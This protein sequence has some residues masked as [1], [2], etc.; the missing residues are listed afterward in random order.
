[1]VYKHKYTA[2]GN[3]AVETRIASDQS[4]IANAI[5]KDIPEHLFVS[6]VMIGGYARGEGGFSYVHGR[7]QAY[8]DYDYFLITEDLSAADLATIK[9]KLVVL[10]KDLE[11]EVGVEVD[12]F[13][14]QRS[15]LKT[16]PFTLMYAEMQSGHLVIAGDT[17]ILDEMPRMPL[18]EVAMSEFQRLMINRGSLLLLNK[19]SFKRDP[20]GFELDQ[21]NK[22]INKAALAVGDSILKRHGAYDLSYEVKLAR[23]FALNGPPESLI[24]YYTRAV[25]QKF[26]PKTEGLDR[27]ELISMQADVIELWCKEFEQISERANLELSQRGLV[28]K[29]KQRLRN[30]AV[31]LRDFGASSILRTPS[32]AASYPRD[33]LVLSLSELLSPDGNKDNLASVLR[34]KSDDKQELWHAYFALWHKYS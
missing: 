8:N 17:D 26:I 2:R 16:L 18:Q 23:L 14:L 27:N 3:E 22:Y 21:F 20:E 19:Q 13:P 15:E 31:N 34:S 33:R 24:R 25:D 4:L 29:A 7:P 12:F 11:E 9:S 1:M 6:L 28:Y 30:L 10:A 32:L 5:T